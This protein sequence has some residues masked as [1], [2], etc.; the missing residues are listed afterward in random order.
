LKERITIRQV[1]IDDISKL[2]QLRRI[3]FEAMGYLDI[4]QLNAMEKAANEYFASAIPSKE[5]YG[6]IA[7]TSEK[8]AV[9]AGGLCIDKHPPLPNNL[10]GKI[11][12]IM[13]LVTLPSYQRQGIA[14]RILKEIIKSM[15]EM[16]IHT[17]S[18][19]ATEV[20]KPLYQKLGFKDS[21]EMRCTLKMK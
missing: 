21:N 4:I 17:L 8:K 2:V 1:R 15:Q 13:N 19:H 3:M 11:G 20:G 7:E 10:S 12:Y 16:G 5:F 18:L 14:N 9:A 6:W